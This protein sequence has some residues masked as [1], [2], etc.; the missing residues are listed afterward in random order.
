MYLVYSF[1]FFRLHHMPH[2]TM[3]NV[4]NYMALSL[5]QRHLQELEIQLYKKISITF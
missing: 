3:T 1:S 4:I 5:K 2:I